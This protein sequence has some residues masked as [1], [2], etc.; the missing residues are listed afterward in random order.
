VNDHIVPAAEETR[1]PVGELFRGSIVP[2][3]LGLLAL[4]LI[5]VPFGSDEVVSSAVGGLM[6][7]LAMLVGPLLHQLSRNLDPALSLGIAV[8]GYGTV[9]GLLWAGFSLLNDTSWLIGGFAA[10]GVVVVTV[11]WAIGHMRAALKLRQA[12]YQQEQPTAGR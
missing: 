6:S 3:L 12:L 10:A 4:I 2:A 7:A 11:G 9:V 1:N 8:T 5:S